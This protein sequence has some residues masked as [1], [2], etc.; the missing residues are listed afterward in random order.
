M[1]L[2]HLTDLH[3]NGSADRRN[4]VVT[5]LRMARGLGA[6]HLLLTGD[7]TAYGTTPQV[8]ELAGLLEAEWPKSQGLGRTVVAGNHDGV[9]A[10]DKLFPLPPPVDV[11]GALVVAVDTRFKRRALAF[12]A[13]GAVGKEA[14][15]DIERVSRDPGRPVIL[16]MHHGPH[17]R[18]LD[19]FQ[20]TVGR[21]GLG[22]LLEERPHLHVCCGHDHRHVD[23]GQI[24][25]ANAVAHH[26]KALRLYE[27]SGAGFRVI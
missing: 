8:H 15:S 22:A 23:L 5:A 14:L 18:D 9:G 2:A 16:A 13:L 12:R 10:I 7:L 3:L 1:I 26:D 17:G 11:G 4:R 24:H 25:V 21:K 6:S 20:G 19:L 27:V